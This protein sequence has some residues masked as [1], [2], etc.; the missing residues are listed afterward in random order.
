LAEDGEPEL[1]Y[2]CSGFKQF[3]AHA[4][5]P[6]KQVMHLREQGLTPDAIMADLRGGLLA[7]WKGIGRN[8]PCPCGS[9]RKAKHCC[10]S[11]RP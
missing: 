11:R 9:G 1:N 2:L 3:Y 8:D 6:L 10:W 7:R 4:E 5:Q